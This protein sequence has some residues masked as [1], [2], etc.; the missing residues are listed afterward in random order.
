MTANKLVQKIRKYAIISFILPLITINSCLLLYKFIGGMNYTIYANYNWDKSE[1]SY[2]YNEFKEIR[3]NR[4]A[5]KFTNCPQYKHSVFYNSD[6]DDVT[7]KTNKNK[8]NLNYECIKNYPSSYSL[9]KKISW[10]EKIFIRAIQTNPSGFAKIKNPY[11]YG[12]VSISRTARNFP[13]ILIF[14]TFIILS[15]FLLFLYWKNTLNFFTFLRN[16]DALIKLPKKYFYFGM[17]SCVFLTLHAIFLGVDL[18]SKLFS[19]VRRL[20]I[21]L[22]IVFEVVAQILLTINIFRFKKELKKYINPLILNTK[23]FFVTI[24]FFITFIA[25]IILTFGDPSTA[26]KHSLEWN[27]F[28][29]LLLYYLLSR[30]LWKI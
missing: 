12:E 2:T 13:M 22:F 17:L 15:A 19:K 23:I 5:Y 11:V 26:F 27:Y 10:V 21:I 7:I 28:A 18:D 3:K 24:V 30:L 16:E 6:N 29:F 8:E 25:M 20:I 1:H 4:S 9:F 14:K